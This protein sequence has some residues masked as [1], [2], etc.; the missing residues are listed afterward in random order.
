[1][2]IKDVSRIIIAN[3]STVDNIHTHGLWLKTEGAASAPMSGSRAIWSSLEDRV[4]RLVL[5]RAK[6]PI[7]QLPNANLYSF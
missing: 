6:V 5:L 3:E 7:A 2:S 1:M 4:L